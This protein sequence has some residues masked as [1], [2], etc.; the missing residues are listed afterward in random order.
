MIP[1]GR[2]R[3]AEVDFP[4]AV[5]S[6]HAARE[7]SIRHGHPSTSIVG[8]RK[9]RWQLAGRCSWPY[10]FPTHA[11]HS[12][13]RKH[14]GCTPPAC[15]TAGADGET[16]AEFPDSRLSVA[17]AA[18]AFGRPGRICIRQRWGPA[19]HT[20]LAGKWSPAPHS[21]S[22]THPTRMSAPGRETFLAARRRDSA[23][24]HPGSCGAIRH[25]A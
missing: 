2:K 11:T 8:G 9:G 23:S 16:R 17:I 14:A 10:C 12:A 7:R 3:L 18:H 25:R 4:I 24:R 22:R 20:P 6:K 1:K 13:Y 19:E 21:G 5:V 15:V